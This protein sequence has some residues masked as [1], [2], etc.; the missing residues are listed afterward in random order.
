M[1]SLSPRFQSP[2]PLHEEHDLAGFDSGE[3]DLDRWL[4]QQAHKNEQGG[5]SRTYVICPDKSKMV[6]GYYCLATGAISRGMTTSRVR[7]NMPDPVPV[8][9]WGRLAIDRKYQ[10]Q[11]LGSA[12]LRDAILRTTQAA[13]IAGIRAILVHAISE[14]AKQFYLDRGFL[15]SP[16]DAMTLM[17]PLADADHILRT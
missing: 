3:P 12:L 7:R 5:G 13:Q 11:G 2:Q 8:M 15:A 17:L 4:Q 1:G 6:I 16:T 9:V 10:G 14:Q